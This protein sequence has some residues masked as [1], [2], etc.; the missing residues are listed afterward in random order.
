MRTV[1]ARLARVV[2]GLTPAD[3]AAGVAV[4]DERDVDPA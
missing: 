3:D 2:P 4:Y 1:L